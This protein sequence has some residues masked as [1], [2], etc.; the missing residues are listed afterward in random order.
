MD[1]SAWNPVAT[2]IRI[3]MNDAVLGGLAVTAHAASDLSTAFFDNYSIRNA[4]PPAAPSDL[5]ASALSETQV[6]LTWNDNATDETGFSIER[7]APGAWEVIGTGLPGTTNHLD[8]SMTPSTPATYRV[9]AQ[10]AG[11]WSEYSP[12][13]STT[14]PA[15]VGD[16]IPGWWRLQ[17][18]GDGLS[19]TGDAA[20]GAD[21]DHDGVP[22]MAEY[23]AG[24][25][26]LDSSS[27]FHIQ[28]GRNP[29]GDLN[30]TWSVQTG[31]VY[32]LE[33]KSSLDQTNWD[34]VAD[35]LT[36]A[37]GAV[38]QT[39]VPPPPSLQRFYR[40]TARMM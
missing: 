33:C 39:N 20:A 12:V 35:N 25:D 14:T 37:G 8:E 36:G 28:A 6:L 1:G 40:L 29:D 18:F 26:P 32:R 38:F 34:T 19:D 31:R 2:D 21:P 24:T 5:M 27:V 22:N 13:A 9:R 10:K 7:L 23:V 3:S 15:G 16:G 30:L 17:H 11:A 4:A